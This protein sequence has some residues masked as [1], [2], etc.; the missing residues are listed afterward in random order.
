MFGR[1]V[2]NAEQKSETDNKTVSKN[3]S[4]NGQELPEIQSQ[5]TTRQVYYSWNC[6][7]LSCCVCNW[8]D[9]QLSYNWESC[10][11]ASELGAGKERGILMIS[12][13]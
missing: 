10:P 5:Q 7:L 3:I 1:L 4:E 13:L 8:Q 9:V 6:K 11:F 12:E 2:T